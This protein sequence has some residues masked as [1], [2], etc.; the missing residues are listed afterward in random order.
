MA[1]IT[2]CVAEKC[3][4][5]RKCYRANAILNPYWQSV[6]DFSKRESNKD[7]CEDFIKMSKRSTKC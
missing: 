2:I 7:K 3:H 1:D 4:L 6:A 5:K